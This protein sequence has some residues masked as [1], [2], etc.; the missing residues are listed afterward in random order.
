[1]LF[2]AGPTL[3]ASCS[4]KRFV[5]LK[6]IRAKKTILAAKK[7]FLQQKMIRAAGVQISWVIV[8]HCISSLLAYPWSLI[9]VCTSHLVIVLSTSHLVIVLST[10]YL[11]IVLS[12]SYLVVELIFRIDCHL[13]LQRATE[14]PC[15]SSPTLTGSCVCAGG[16]SWGSEIQCL[17]SHGATG[18]EN[19]GTEE[20]GEGL[21]NALQITASLCVAVSTPEQKQ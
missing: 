20:E 18:G 5:Q 15:R 3:I 21:A 16:R 17:L 1:M 6:K 19:A 7:R 8:C 12:T 4:K 11:V 2:T 14:N 13:I 10:S 9:L